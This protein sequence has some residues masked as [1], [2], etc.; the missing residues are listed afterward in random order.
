M[1]LPRPLL[2]IL[3][4]SVG[5]IATAIPAAAAA[6]A[7]AAIDTPPLSKYP[8]PWARGGGDGWDEAYAKAREFVAALT[9][10]EKVNLTTG[11]GWESD[12]CIGMTGA[13]PRLGFQGFCLMDGPL[14]IRYSAFDPS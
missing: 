12:R 1:H 5:F 2:S 3:S 9:L 4:L 14:G 11:T 6:A 7:A 8:S 10:P 13:V